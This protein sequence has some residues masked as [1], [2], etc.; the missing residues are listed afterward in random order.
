MD[1]HHRMDRQTFTHVMVG[2]QVKE[3]K[4]GGGRPNREC[5]MSSCVCVVG[6]ILASKRL[7]YDDYWRPHDKPTVEV[8]VNRARSSYQRHTNHVNKLYIMKPMGP[9]YRVL[10]FS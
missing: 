5:V 2:R 4:T 3:G 10:S 9:G 6:L 8:P 7:S 1:S